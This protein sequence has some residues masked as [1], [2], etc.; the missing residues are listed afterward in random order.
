M[1]QIKKKKTWNV[2]VLVNQGIN[3]FNSEC[4]KYVK[5]NMIPP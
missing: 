3:N 5:E 2:R 1:N 4:L